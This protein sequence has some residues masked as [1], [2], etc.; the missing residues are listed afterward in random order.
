MTYTLHTPEGYKPLPLPYRNAW[1][2]ALRSGEYEQGKHF[3]MR[4]TDASTCYCCLGVL[5]KIQGRLTPDGW[6]AQE[7]TPKTA[8]ELAYDN[9]CF[10][11]FRF[12]DGTFPHKC[13]AQLEKSKCSSLASCND[14]GLSFLQ[15][16]DIIEQ[17]YVEPTSN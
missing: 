14:N 15:I 5:S 9:P 1:L 4:E 10:P 7:P 2:S 13:Y 3:L 12:G 17:L 11:T 6:D 16:A 8:E